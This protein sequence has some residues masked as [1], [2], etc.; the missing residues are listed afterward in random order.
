MKNSIFGFLFESDKKKREKYIEER[1][2]Y[3]FK[4]FFDGNDYKQPQSNYSSHYYEFH[5]FEFKHSKDEIIMTVTLGKPGLFIGKG[6]NQIARLASYINIGV[7]KKVKIS[8]KEFN[9]WK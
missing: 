5:S 2:K 8:I 9:I 6:G 4:I 7:N 1:I 3:F